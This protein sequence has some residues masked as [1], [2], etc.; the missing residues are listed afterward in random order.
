MT[1]RYTVKP[2]DD[3]EGF[4]GQHR[5]SP[6]E[7]SWSSTRDLLAR[8]LRQLR[9]RNVILEIDVLPGHIRLDGELKANAR[10]SSPAVRLHFDT[11]DGH[12]TFPADRFA[13]WHDNVR[14]I[15]LAMEALRKIERYGVGRG[16]EQYSGFLQ[17][18][19][20]QGIALGGMTR[21]DAINLLDE[22]AD[23]DWGLT[24]DGP[25]I[26]RLA[27]AGAHPDRNGGNRAAWDQVEQAAKVLG[28]TS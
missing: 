19:A 21:D 15:A 18:E 1:S 25:R 22:Y 6:F 16:D 20:G 7:S 17:L 10:V 26:Y 12:V 24:E 11:D 3:R 13:S 9:A 14:A 5:P 2:L 8:E 27:R 23:R 4:K 28:L